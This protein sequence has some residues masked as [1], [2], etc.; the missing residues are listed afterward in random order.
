MIQVGL[1]NRGRLGS[2]VEDVVVPNEV[3]LVV[4]VT[5]V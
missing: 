4:A 5:A 3:V 1:A 2:L